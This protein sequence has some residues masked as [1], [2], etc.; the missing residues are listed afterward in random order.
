MTP[1]P[2]GFV[3]IEA[4]TKFSRLFTGVV[5]TARETGALPAHIKLGDTRA[6]EAEAGIEAGYAALSAAAEEG[7]QRALKRG[8]TLE[9]SDAMYDLGNPPGDRQP[10]ARAG[11]SGFHNPIPTLGSGATG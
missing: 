6:H 8:T 9:G 10:A 7:P 2:G 3:R 1:V 4:R 11:A 5:V